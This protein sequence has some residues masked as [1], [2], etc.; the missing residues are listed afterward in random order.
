MTE[1]G[2]S[3]WGRDQ[4]QEFGALKERVRSLEEGR[5][6]DQQRNWWAI[7]TVIA[8]LVSNFFQN[9]PAILKLIGG[10]AK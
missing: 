6:K 5:S 3:S 1:R 4:W 9:L 8:L 2:G 10:V 7:S